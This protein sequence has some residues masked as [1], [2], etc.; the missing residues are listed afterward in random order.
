MDFVYV[1][2]FGQRSTSEGDFI[3]ADCYVDTDGAAEAAAAFIRK[4]FPGG[5][6]IEVT[7]DEHER[8]H[9]VRQWNGMLYSVWLERLAVNN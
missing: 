6:F 9:I 3:S 2:T 8:C 1:V 5:E 4:E 7:P